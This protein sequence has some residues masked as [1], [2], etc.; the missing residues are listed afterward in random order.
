MI[1]D[2]NQLIICSQFYKLSK[3]WPEQLISAPS[4]ISRSCSNSWNPASMA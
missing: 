3:G 4:G 2:N 1:L